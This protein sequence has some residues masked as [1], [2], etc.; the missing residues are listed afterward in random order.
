MGLWSCGYFH[1]RKFCQ[2][3]RDTA[4][5]DDMLAAVSRCE[6]KMTALA[7]APS[8]TKRGLGGSAC[9]LAAWQCVVPVPTSSLKK[10][11]AV[12]PGADLLHGV[13]G[14]ELAACCYEYQ[15]DAFDSL[16]SVFRCRDVFCCLFFV[17]Y[18]IGM[19]STHF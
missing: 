13:N 15:T 14:S 7:I 11:A 1:L 10:K 4:I 19:V 12:I 5:S 2:H 8:R 3:T 6:A 17:V 18:W 9:S 16:A